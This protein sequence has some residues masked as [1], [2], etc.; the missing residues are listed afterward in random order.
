MCLSSELTNNGDSVKVVIPPT[1]HDVIHPCD[2]Y[3]DVAIAFGYN[4]IKR[5]LPKTNTIGSQFP[6]NKLTDLLR[7]PIAEAGF[8]EALTFTLVRTIYL[9]LYINFTFILFVLIWSLI[10]KKFSFINLYEF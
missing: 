1:R 8:T 5:T 7:Y 6:V 3:E 10:A 9:S 2:I 4:N